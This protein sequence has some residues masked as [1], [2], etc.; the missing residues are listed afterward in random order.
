MF[1]AF[2]ECVCLVKL[3]PAGQAIDRHECGTKGKCVI[4]LGESDRRKAGQ[5]K[6]E[7][8]RTEATL[9]H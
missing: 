2:K 7:R 6:G 5:E 3:Q 8:P 1:P 4:P 9:L